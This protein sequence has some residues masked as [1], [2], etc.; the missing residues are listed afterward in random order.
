MKENNNENAVKDLEIKNIIKPH[1]NLKSSF[2]SFRNYYPKDKKN[3]QSY[4]FKK[5]Y[6]ILK[7][8]KSNFIYNIFIIM[9]VEI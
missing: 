2:N 1:N 5:N 4:L 3:I 9:T 7:K 6:H 8:Q